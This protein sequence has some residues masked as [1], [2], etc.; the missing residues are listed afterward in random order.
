KNET[1]TARSKIYPVEYGFAV[2]RRSI[3][4]GELKTPQLNPFATETNVCLTGQ[5]K[6]AKEG[7]IVFSFVTRF[8]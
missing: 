6:V 1:L 2:D 7:K 3:Q 5:A 4:P 8:A